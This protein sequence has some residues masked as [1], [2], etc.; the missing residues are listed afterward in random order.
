M[1]TG[2]FQPFVLAVEFR[3]PT[4]QFLE[5]EKRLRDGVGDLPDALFA[6]L[7]RAAAQA[8]LAQ[9]ALLAQ[10]REAGV[11]QDAVEPGQ[12]RIPVAEGLA[13]PVGLGKAS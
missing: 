12:E 2:E 1:Q 3:I 13:R 8:V 10:V 7:V 11:A 5:L 4:R 6:V 9:P